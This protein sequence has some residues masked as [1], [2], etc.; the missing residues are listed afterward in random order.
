L[1]IFSDEAN[2]LFYEEFS[3]K[4]PLKLI[5]NKTCFFLRISP[6]NPV[7]WE[8]VIFGNATFFFKLLLAWRLAA[9]GFGYAANLIKNVL[10]VHRHHCYI[11]SQKSRRNGL[12]V[13]RSCWTLARSPRHVNGSFVSR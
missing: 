9:V 13:R 8:P 6:P 3:C 7:I 2:E 10:L 12:V 4:G 5:M 1:F 11:I